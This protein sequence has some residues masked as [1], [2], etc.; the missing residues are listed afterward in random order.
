MRHFELRVDTAFESVV[1]ACGDPRRPH[2]WITPAIV[3]AYTR[4]HDLGWAHSVE[5]WLDGE[6]VGG[7]YGVGIGAFQAAACGCDGDQHQRRGGCRH[8]DRPRRCS[9]LQRQHVVVVGPHG[10]EPRWRVR[11]SR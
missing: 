4:L 11:P 2:G 8:G 5:T 9:G 7:L 3:T 10:D 1:R 6:L